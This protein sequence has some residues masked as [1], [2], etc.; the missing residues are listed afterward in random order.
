M[1]ITF[2]FQ[3]QFVIFFSGINELPYLQLDL[4]AELRGKGAGQVRRR[5]KSQSLRLQSR[6]EEK[7]LFYLVL[8]CFCFLV[9]VCLR[10]S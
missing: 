9:C 3:V 2:N 6:I 4:G 7:G 10:L 1:G 8:P 5:Y